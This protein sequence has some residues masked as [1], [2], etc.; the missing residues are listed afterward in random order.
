MSISVRSCQ[1]AGDEIAGLQTQSC[2]IRSQL[3]FRDPV[4]RGRRGGTIAARA[5]SHPLKEA[6][7]HPEALRT[8]CRLTI[9]TC[10]ASNCP[11]PPSLN[12]ELAQR[13]LLTP[14]NPGISMHF[15]T[16]NRRKQLLPLKRPVDS[17]SPGRP[18]IPWPHACHGSAPG[19]MASGSCLA[20]PWHL[21]AACAG[22]EWPRTI[23]KKTRA[24]TA[25][26]HMAPWISDALGMK[27][28]ANDPKWVNI[29][30]RGHTLR[31]IR[32]TAS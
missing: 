6:A 4:L 24:R 19:S 11:P 1:G 14:P 18:L 16:E 30:W 7:A 31:A 27:R 23:K 8:P 15:S 20:A 22:G 26:I 3:I 2:A 21:P 13:P 10:R 5:A 29:F 17:S 12:S 32:T 9:C 28:D 25:S